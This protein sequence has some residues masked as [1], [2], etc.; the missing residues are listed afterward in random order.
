MSEIINNLILL[1]SRASSAT[2]L[3]VLTGMGSATCT[4]RN[5]AYTNKTVRLTRDLKKLWI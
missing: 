1:W 2:T 3:L 5:Q 4:A